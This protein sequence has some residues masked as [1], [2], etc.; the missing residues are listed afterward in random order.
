M[1]AD[2]L[3]FRISPIKRNPASSR[4]T[5]KREDDMIVERVA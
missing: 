5:G 4:R 3:R 1:R 2:R